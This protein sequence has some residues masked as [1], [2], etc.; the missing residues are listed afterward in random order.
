M[1]YFKKQILKRRIEKLSKKNI[2]VNEKI[3]KFFNEINKKDFEYL[4]NDKKICRK[5]FHYFILEKNKNNITL[6]TK[7]LYLIE[8]L[9]DNIYKLKELNNIE[10][11]LPIFLN[12]LSLPNI[13]NLNKY[14]KEQNIE[15]EN[16][17]LNYYLMCLYQ[18]KEVEK[19]DLNNASIQEMHCSISMQLTE[20]LLKFIDY[21]E[22]ST[23]E[24]NK[25]KISRLK[26]MNN[27][28]RF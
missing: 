22:Y 3:N 25:Y 13:L 24:V 12:Y 9:I 7:S 10:V 23:E 19:I 28:E 21:Y 17:N 1:N 2:H 15:I 11:T 6:Y 18:K 20:N 4:I 26:L 8:V 5:I 27:I 14:L 16:K